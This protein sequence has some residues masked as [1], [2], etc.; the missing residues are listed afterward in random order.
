MKITTGLCVAFIC[1]FAAGAF[2][3]T[4]NLLKNG[5]FEHGMDTT[6]GEPVGW[7]TKIIGIIPIPEYMDPVRKKGR[8][9]KYEFKCG[10]GH[11]WGNVRPWAYLYCPECGR[12]NVGLEDSGDLYDDNETCVKIGA[13]KTGRGLEYDLPVAIGNNEGV[14]VV[15][16]LIKAE[17]GAG[18]EISFDTKASKSHVRLFVECF[19]EETGDDLATRWVK[20]LPAKSNPLRQTVRLKRVFRKHIDAK[21]PTTWT[22]FSE[23]FVAPDRYAF[24]WM[25]VSLYAYLPGEAAFDNVVLRKLTPAELAAHRSANPG[26]KDKR[27]R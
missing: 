15:S 5:N 27:L 16:D 2:A 1:L 4:P 23:T 6:A 10:C 19:R 14:R 17:P 11:I 8:T 7:H 9:G 22:H 24:D 18:Y 21:T 12:L 3:R 26:P 25:Y 20:T 13:G